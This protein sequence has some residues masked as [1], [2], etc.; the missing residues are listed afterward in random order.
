MA[1]RALRICDDDN[2]EQELS[3]LRHV[4][5]LNGYSSKQIST[6]FKQARS[7]H[8]NP[9]HS[10]APPH[11]T[12]FLPFV[13]GISHKIARIL[14]KKGVRCA[15]K[16]L[17]SI[18]SRLPPLKDSKDDLSASGVYK[19][20]C[21]CGSLYI[22]ETGRSFSTRIK[23]HSADIR[24]ERVLKSALAEHSSSTKHHICLENAK[25]LLKED[26]FF[27]R[28]LKEAIAIFNHPSNLN[29]DEG[30]ALNLSWHPLLSSLKVRHPLPL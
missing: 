30:W 18:R 1:L 24:H 23:E 14:I 12:A 21:S 13:E 26:N 19:I 22:G 4:F 3:H 25:I 11:P 28:K 27:K 7:F 10:P 9:A 17:S 29:H 16:P 2:V 8:S 20:P 15:F 6:A 5:R